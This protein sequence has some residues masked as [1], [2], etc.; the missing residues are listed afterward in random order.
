[1]SKI[2]VTGGTGY[3]G[4]HACITFI[5]S[6]LVPV[7]VDNL[8]NSNIKVLDRIKRITGYLPEF[9]EGDLRD[10]TLMNE[11]FEKHNFDSVIHFAG[12]K[13]VGESVKKPLEY[14]D[15]NLSATLSLLQ[16]MTKTDVKTL[17]FSSSA[18]VYGIPENVPIDEN[19]VLSPTNPYGQTKLMIEQILT[20]AANS[21]PEWRIACLRYFNPVGAHESGLI[22]EDP[23]G[24]P[25]NLLPNIAQV[26]IGKRQQFLVFGDDYPTP[27]GTG[28]RDYIHVMD[29]AE[30][31]LAALHYLQNS[32][33]VTAVNLGTGYGLSVLE[34]VTAFEAASGRTVP[35]KIMPRRPGDVAICYANPDRARKLFGWSAK[36][37]IAQ[38]CQD[39]WNW[40][41]LNPSC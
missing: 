12:L 24:I 10:D 29:L 16:A 26:A 13:A 40:Q 3:I 8:R 2:L 19:S 38:M 22:G 25:N 7:I 14:F 17:I 31:H 20:D 4:S 23:L 32:S 27:D 18:T 33:G 15:N 21:D 9:F 28:I 37:T 5:E 11:I 39:V 34:L 6:G 1:M 30:G 35:Y 41:S 36:R